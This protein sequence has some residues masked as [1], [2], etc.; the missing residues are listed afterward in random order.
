M[1]SLPH[2]TSHHHHHHH[3]IF[4]FTKYAKKHINRHVKGENSQKAKRGQ[5]RAITQLRK[6]TTSNL[7]TKESNTRKK[8]TYITHPS[9]PSMKRN[10]QHIK[11][12]IIQRWRIHRTHSHRNIDKTKQKQNIKTSQAPKIRKRYIIITLSG[13]KYVILQLLSKCF[14][15]KRKFNFFSMFR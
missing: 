15:I 7:P 5:K 10:Q 2:L 6:K 3:H 14:D 4:I 13:R 9:K 12:T 1:Q 8:K 11:H